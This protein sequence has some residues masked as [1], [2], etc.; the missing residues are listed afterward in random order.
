MYMYVHII[1]RINFDFSFRK[2]FDKKVEEYQ[3]AQK[4]KKDKEIEELVER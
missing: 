2:I 3:E 1:L 4:V